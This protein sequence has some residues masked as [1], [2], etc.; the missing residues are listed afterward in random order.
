[1]SEIGGVLTAM[2]TP[3]DDD[4]AVDYDAAR[5]L[6]RHLV[7]EGCHG[8]VV[9]GTTGES[10]TLSDDEKVRLLR[11]RARRGRRLGDRDRGHRVQRHGPHRRA[12]APCARA[13]R[14]RRARGHAVLQP[15][16]RGRAAGALR[17]R[18]RGRGRHAGDRLQHPVAL[19]HQPVAGAAG[20]ARRD[21]RQRRRR[22][23]G[24]QRR[25]RA[26][27]RP[28]DPRRQRRRLRPHARVRRR[29]RDPRGLQRRR[30]RSCA[31]STTQRWPARASA[32]R[33]STESSPR[34]TR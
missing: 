28:G 21:A 23:A 19:R 30:P 9:A 6:A 31:R 26:D 12:D 33:N 4:G 25:A 24:Q 10:A 20:G 34:S 22:Q 3:F 16:Q 7:D 2:V 29:G 5:R 27:R 32:W 15:A 1:M 17:R 11:G 8:L 14:R 13:R 18:I